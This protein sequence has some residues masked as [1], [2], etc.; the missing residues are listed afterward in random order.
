M[1][2]ANNGETVKLNADLRIFWTDLSS[3]RVQYVNPNTEQIEDV[4]RVNCK[5]LGQLCRGM[6][7]FDVCW[8]VKRTELIDRIATKI[9]KANL[10]WF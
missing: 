8:V 5:G 6:S 2:R 3:V 1:V 10:H 7:K 9:I 4:C